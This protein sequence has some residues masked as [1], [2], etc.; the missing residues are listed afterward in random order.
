[1]GERIRPT[2]V[3]LAIV[4]VLAGG[5]GTATTLRPTSVAVPPPATSTLPVSSETLVCPDPSA[6]GAASTTDV[7]AGA[8]SVAGAAG[9][10]VKT[11]SSGG[12]IGLA[13]L[14]PAVTPEATVD[15]RGPTANVEVTAPDAPPVVVRALGAVSPG[16]AAAQVTE[17]TDGQA[18]G[19]AATRCGAPGTDFWFVGLGTEV[20]HTSQLHLVN[21]EQAAASVQILLAGSDGPISIGGLG[22]V[23]VPAR[24][25][26]SYDLDALAPDQTALAVHVVARTGRVAAGVFDQR[27]IDLDSAGAD[28][29]PTAAAP[30]RT[31][32][33]PGVSAGTGARILQ[34]LAPGELDTRVQVRFLTSTG[35]I[36]PVGLEDVQLEAGAVTSVAIDPVARGA[37][38]AIELRADQPLVA[39]LRAVTGAADAEHDMAYTAGAVS[40]TDPTYVVGAHGGTGWTSRLLLTASAAA[41][42]VTVTY[43]SADTGAVLGRNEVSL[44]AGATTTAPDLASAPQTYGVLVT[45][46]GPGVLGVLQLSVVR[47][48][49]QFLSLVPLVSDAL[50]VDVPRVRQDLSTGLSPQQR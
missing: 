48:G 6:L 2:Y 47:D 10:A 25:S 33:V 7:F 9:P 20:G 31:V 40:L 18:R 5:L 28:W 15:T 30:A 19:L 36:T 42:S 22:N 34:L 45:P 43:V 41:T 24:S 16:L 13:A 50:V 32:V 29:L 11:S 1:M 35:A 21:A 39:G 46:H 27:V 38:V 49:V 3:L 14:D 17:T 8:S 37:A 26:A 4:V 44:D 23:V 12:S